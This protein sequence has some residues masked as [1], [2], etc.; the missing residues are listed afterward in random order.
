MSK[1]HPSVV[2]LCRHLSH[3]P[4]DRATSAS[5]AKGAGYSA[6][7]AAYNTL[8]RVGLGSMKEHPPFEGPAEELPLRQLQAILAW[9]FEA[10]FFV[11]HL[12]HHPES[13]DPVYQLL[14]YDLRFLTESGDPLR[15]VREQPRQEELVRICL[16]R[17]GIHPR[18]EDEAQNVEHLKAVATAPIREQEVKQALQARRDAAAAPKTGRE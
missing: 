8:V 11:H 18:G 16:F 9:V 15:F 4:L 14:A 1:N 12:E 6:A 5:L 7:E 13:Q 10:P 2:E 17:L 3:F